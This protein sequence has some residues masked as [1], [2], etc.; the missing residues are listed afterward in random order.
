MARNY[1]DTSTNTIEEAKE[2]AMKKL[3]EEL[4][5]SMSSID[6]SNT[7]TSEEMLAHFNLK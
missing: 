6:N 2:I 3:L 7:L 4:D 5:K 1:I